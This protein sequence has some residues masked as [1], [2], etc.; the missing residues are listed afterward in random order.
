MPL[1]QA[2]AAAIYTDHGLGS[3]NRGETLIIFTA[4]R[5]VA[6]VIRPDFAALHSGYVLR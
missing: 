3:K 5:N 6:L 4:E 2:A 1:I